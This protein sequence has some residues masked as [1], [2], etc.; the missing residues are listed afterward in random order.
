MSERSFT[1]EKSDHNFG[2]IAACSGYALIAVSWFILG[3]GVIGWTIPGIG[4]LLYSGSLYRVAAILIA[5]CGLWMLGASRKPIDVASLLA[6]AGVLGCLYLGHQVGR[7]YPQALRDHFRWIALVWTV[8][9][10]ILWLFSI[11]SEPFCKS[12]LLLLFALGSLASAIGEWIHFP[13]AT[14]LGGVIFLICSLLAAITSVREG[15]RGPGTKRT[16]PVRDTY[17]SEKR[18]IIHFKN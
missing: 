9:F 7:E 10:T 8:C 11:P 18:F 15:W 16:V 2:A 17:P 14:W 12:L 13:E 1:T 5:G 3:A 4:T 6:M